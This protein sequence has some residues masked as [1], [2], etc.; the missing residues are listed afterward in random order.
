MRFLS[1]L[2]LLCL[3]GFS[4]SAQQVYPTDYFDW[5]L[6]LPVSLSA[7]FGEI[8]PNHFHSGLDLRIGGKIGEPVYAPADG[9]VS[10]I[11]VSPWGGGKVLYI[12]HSNGY[13]TVYMHLND[14]CGEIGRWVRNYQYSHRTFQFDVELG[15]DTIHVTRGQLIAHAGNTG[16]S[17]GPHLHYEIRYAHNDQPINPLY[18]GVN[19][20]DAIPPT[21]RN[22]KVYPADAL[23]TV[24]GRHAAVALKETKRGKKPVTIRHDTVRVEGRCYVGI[25][26]TDVSE[27]S[28]G[29]NGVERIEL[30]V[31]D[32]L[33]YTYSVP[34]FLFEDTRVVNSLIDYSEYQRSREYY[35]LTRQ[36]RGPQNTQSKAQSD[37]GILN[38]PDGGLHKL[39]YVVRDY[40][41]NKAEQVFFIRATRGETEETAST[42][43][44]E[45]VDVVGEPIT[46]YKKWQFVRPGFYVNMD[47]NTV[48]DNDYVT[49][50]CGQRSGYL[51]PT[52]SLMLQRHPLPPHKSFKVFIAEPPCAEVLKSKM[53]VV[54]IEGKRRTACATR[55]IDGWLE[56]TT[57]AFGTFAVTLDTV[58]P[59]LK[60]LNFTSG[61]AFVG[62]ELR[63]K[64]TD[65]LS[66]LQAYHCFVN[67]QWV[68]S[69]YDG[70]TTTLT[71][72]VRAALEKGRNE[73]R[74]EVYDVVGNRKE[75][76]F[77]I[78]R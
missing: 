64:L 58:A 26:A 30:F 75:W 73:V 11:N 63:S 3:L 33:F 16:G 40:K 60:P 22:V 41:G 5:P 68:L 12:T 53:V 23:S 13:R 56:A 54:C 44:V 17:G 15:D 66:G 74:Y 55:R 1:L 4:V 42:D 61:K 45:N 25:Y 31:D 43:F 24:E 10:R 37:G 59:Q 52:H 57:R 76:K 6:R 48:Y 14:F 69:E 78:V 18:F 77:T 21:I 2:T 72:D 50:A 9:Y 27:P 67:G 47:E 20:S 71:T 39:R 29:K 49:Y 28:T 32:K 34:T 36:L 19:Y 8:R 38:F 65:D 62:T 51:S 7:S 35:L 46:Y 70:K